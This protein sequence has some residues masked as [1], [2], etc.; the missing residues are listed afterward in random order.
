ML[1]KIINFRRVQPRLPRDL[2]RLIRYLLTPKLSANLSGDRLLGPPQLH[3]LLLSV[4]PKGTGISKA[5]DDITAQ[6]VRYCRTATIGKEM[7]AVWYVHIICSFAP[8]ASPDLKT[9]P[10][11]HR[12]PP[13]W[14]SQSKNALRISQ[15]ALDNLGWSDLQP[16]FFV[17][18]GDRRHIHVHAVIAIP[19]FNSKPWNIL[20]FSRMFIDEIAKTCANA[21]SL[22]ISAQELKP[23]Y[24]NW[25][26]LPDLP[27][28]EVKT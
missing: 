11:T 5:A 23:Y 21:F 13:Q 8:V 24:K 9:P 10:D 4:L 2:R 20:R 22:P 25:S 15:D 26:N 14:K 3:H 7:P 1:I 6:F 18:H 12:Y 19:I 28:P 16:G 17:V 27:I